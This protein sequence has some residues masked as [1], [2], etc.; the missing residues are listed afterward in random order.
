MEVA[1][2]LKI[3]KNSNNMTAAIEIPKTRNATFVERFKNWI[4]S[5]SRVK[6]SIMRLAIYVLLIDLA[7]IF[8]F[9]FI[10]M[11][12]TSLKSNAD[13]NDLTVN[14]I[15]KSLKWENYYIAFDLLSY[16]DFFKNSLIITV[17]ATLGHA[18]SCSFIGYGFARYNFP[19]KNVL[20]LLVIISFIVPVQTLIVPYYLIYTNLGWKDTFLPLIVPTFFGFGLK[21]GL[22]IFLFRQYYLGLPKE[23]EEAA[24]IDG[25]GFFRTY[26]EIVMPI[27]SS[28]F[29][30]TCVLSMV[31][32]W[33][34]YYEPAIYID[35]GS[36]AVL[37]SKINYVVSLVNAPPE[38]LFDA[39][40]LVEGEDTLNDAVVMAGTFLI[41]L[42]VLIV[43][44]FLQNKFIQGIESS[45][46]KG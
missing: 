21:G 33:N 41:I 9:P 17:F 43:F 10:Y 5:G 34:D 3:N 36:M 46:I 35:K 26:L 6:D 7:F 16:F 39:L 24:K 42:P 14:W 1:R 15:P 23:L 44:A 4:T 29:L 19:L 13:L 38:E 12:V 2:R 31:W 8:L 28:I 22:Y 30:V 32:H 40:E 18:I 11:V 25:C 37:P 45:G 20:F 27:A